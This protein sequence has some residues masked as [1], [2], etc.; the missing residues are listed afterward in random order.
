MQTNN[1]EHPHHPPKCSA[2]QHILKTT[3]TKGLPHSA[4]KLSYCHG[5]NSVDLTSSAS[6][7]AEEPSRAARCS[8]YLPL[9]WYISK[10]PHGVGVI[11][12]VRSNHFGVNW[13]PLSSRCLFSALCLSSR[14]Q[15]SNS[16]ESKHR[17]SKSASLNLN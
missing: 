15:V 12:S 14:L 2:K 7:L 3:N 8:V 4:D 13:W 10:S 16:T 11:S 17:A 6:V 1:R 5:L 9:Y